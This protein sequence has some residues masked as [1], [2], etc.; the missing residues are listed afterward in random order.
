MGGSKEIKGKKLKDLVSW[1]RHLWPNRPLRC[2][3][4]EMF[5]L[6]TDPGSLRWNTGTVPK[7]KPKWS[8]RPIQ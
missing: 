5:Q 6:P 1:T 7:L 2:S 8:S 4:S 3:G